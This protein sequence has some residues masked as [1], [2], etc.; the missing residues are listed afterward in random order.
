MKPTEI[1]FIRLSDGT[2]LYIGS[3]DDGRIAVQRPNPLTVS[4]MAWIPIARDALIPSWEG[5]K[6]SK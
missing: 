6:K 3:W 5:A 1:V 2:G 4:G